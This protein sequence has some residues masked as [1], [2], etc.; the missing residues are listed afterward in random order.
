MVDAEA[1]APAP[2]ELV[3]PVDRERRLLRLQRAR[4]K[5]GRV[6]LA[7]SSRVE[8]AAGS[9]RWSKSS[10][11]SPAYGS[12]GASLRHRQ[13]ALDQHAKRLVRQVGRGHGGRALADEQPQADLLAFG[14]ADALDLAEAD[15]HAR[16]AV[17]GVKRVG[18]GRTGGDAALD[19]RFCDAA[20][21]VGT[22][23]CGR[24]PSAR[25]R[26]TTSM[27]RNTSKPQLRLERNRRSAS[28]PSPGSARSA[29]LARCSAAGTSARSASQSGRTGQ[30]AAPH[31]S[32]AMHVEDGDAGARLVAEPPRRRLHPDQRVVLH[33]LDRVERVVADHPGNASEP[34]QQTA[35]S[36]SC[37]SPPASRP[38]PPGE[39]EAEPC[40]RPPGDPLHEGIGRD[41]REA[42]RARSAPQAS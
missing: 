8:D 3:T 12:S 19:Q 17:A 29:W 10:G 23:A 30:I 35:A 7:R 20:G 9:P 27:A 42:A 25:E 39:D 36:R 18:G 37:R 28:S 22:I 33:V 5:L 21:V 40:L 32:S 11:A 13:A 31:K 34:Q 38:A 1:L 16:R 15:L 26:P 14:A 2:L 4:A 6:R 24:A 41:R